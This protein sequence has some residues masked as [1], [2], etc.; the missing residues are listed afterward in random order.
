ML[1][2]I[3]VKELQDSLFAQLDKKWM[4]ITAGTG[5]NCNTMTAGWGR[6][7]RI[8]GSACCYLLCATPALHQRISGP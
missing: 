1:Q 2:S 6:T 4:L 7:G 5:E 3:D 8:V